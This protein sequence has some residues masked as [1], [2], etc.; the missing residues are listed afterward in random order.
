MALVESAAIPD[1]V[2]FYD[3]RCDL[4]A[5]AASFKVVESGDAGD[6]LSAVKGVVLGTLFGGLIWTAMIWALL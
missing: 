5:D 6:R 1:E 2:L 4:P 3:R